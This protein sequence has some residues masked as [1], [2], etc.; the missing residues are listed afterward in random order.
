MQ[1]SAE[2]PDVTISGDRV[3]YIDESST[4]LRGREL[5]SQLYQTW[6]EPSYKSLVV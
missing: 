6:S 3:G 5:S 4:F 1:G 2:L